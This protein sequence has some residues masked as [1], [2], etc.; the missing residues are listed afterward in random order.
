MIEYIR[1]LNRIISAV[2]DLLN[3]EMKFEPPERAGTHLF[4]LGSLRKFDGG[5]DF[6]QSASARAKDVLF[7]SAAMC[8]YDDRLDP[9]SPSDFDKFWSECRDPNGPAVCRAVY[10]ALLRQSSEQA[11]G[12]RILKS[13]QEEYNC[14]AAEEELYWRFRYLWESVGL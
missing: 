9:D 7:I 4:W 10:K 1:S 12:G 5:I 8:L 6:T 3:I 11:I 2:P 14:D 13:R